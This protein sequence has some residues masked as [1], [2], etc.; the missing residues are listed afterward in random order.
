MDDEILQLCLD[1]VASSSLSVT[2][3]Q[4]WQKRLKESG[5]DREVYELL[6]NDVRAA[7]NQDQQKLD[8]ELEKV[9]EEI[10]ET[11]NQFNQQ[12]KQLSEQ[13][14]ETS[15]EIQKKQDE[16]ALSQIRNKLGM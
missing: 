11:T 14:K 3:K 6:Q 2:N 12:V 9:I 8:Q 7:Y 5:V 10:D 1:L 15:K 16:N 4:A 13:A